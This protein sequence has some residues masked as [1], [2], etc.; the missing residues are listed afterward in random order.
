MGWL[1]QP[2]PAQDHGVQPDW[3]TTLNQT[4]QTTT[5]TTP[6]PIDSLSS[7]GVLYHVSNNGGN[8][9]M[10]LGFTDSTSVTVT[11]SA[12]DW[13]GPTNPPGAG[14]GV[15][16]Q[17]RLGNTT[18]VR[19]VGV[20]NGNT[21]SVY[22][23]DSLAVTE[24]VVTTASISG[25]GLGNIAGKSLSSITFQ[26]PNQPLRGYAIFAATV[27]TGLGPPANDNC[28]SPTTVLAGTTSTSN[29][30]AT[31]STTSS[32]GV[33]DTSDVWYRFVA[34]SSG[35]VEARTC[36]ASFDTTLAIYTTC[37]GASI[38]C[39]DNA[40]GLASRVQWNAVANQAYLIRAA[41]NNGATGNFDLTIDTAAVA[42]NDLPVALNYN[43]NGMV[44]N[45][46]SGQP[47]ASTA[48]GG[49][50]RSISDRGFDASGAVWLDQRRHAFRHRLHP[51]LNR[52]LR[53][54]PGHRSPWPNR[55]G[56]STRLGC[57]RQWR[58]SRHCPCVADQSRPV[59]AAAHQP[60]PAQ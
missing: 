27:V 12:S 34:P 10:V 48:D 20:D 36:G 24:A 41:G 38:A 42:H 29:L 3:L 4:S 55:P 31:G 22:P 43:W 21:T 45:G 6:L 7:I 14:P 30:R 51:L 53:R 52:Q 1:G 57:R 8:F 5:L 46:E 25:A 50:Y 56:L 16:S 44:H 15:S 9:D 49:G 35:L 2:R 19:A 60:R 39:N 13:F 33:N 40:C 26:N 59:H 28:T 47:D 23:T 54:P 17:S 58:R 37:G 11:L 18:Y 32:C